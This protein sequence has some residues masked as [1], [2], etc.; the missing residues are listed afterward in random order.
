M[1][2][3]DILNL[4]AILAAA[5]LIRSFVKGI[6]AK[7]FAN[8]VMRQKVVNGQIWLMSAAAKRIS[9]T[10]K[11]DHPRIPWEQLSQMGESVLRSPEG[12]NPNAVFQFARKSVPE[13]ILMISGLTPTHK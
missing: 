8:D 11:K 13:L 9:E 4:K 6:D 7:I 2:D 3:P 1:S 5:Q 10:F 12:D